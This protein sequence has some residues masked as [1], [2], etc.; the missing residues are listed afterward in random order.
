MRRLITLLFI[1]ALVAGLGLTIF[2]PAHDLTPP[3]QIA[4]ALLLALVILDRLF[5]LFP[6]RRRSRIPPSQVAEI[7]RLYFRAMREM[8]NEHANL[9][10]VINDLQRIL[11]IDPRYKNARHYLKRALILQAEGGSLSSNS[12]NNRSRTSAEFMRLQEQLI[13]PDPAVR[14]SVVMELIQYG[15]VA[16]DPLIAL[17]MDEDSDVRVHAATALGWVGGRDAVQPLMVALEDDNPYVRR[18]AARAM[19]WVVD[20][21]AIEGLI[22]ALKDEDNYVRQYA[23]RALGWSQDRRAVGPLLELLSAEQN[24]DVRDYAFTALDDLGERN[25]RVERPVEVAE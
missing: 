11:S 8:L 5:G 18:Y 3:L 7:E 23:A 12:A 6:P 22:R 20:E 21:T 15:E 4:A 19:C 14:K 10:Q 25:V 16:T 24:A 1:F 13:D 9:V 2:A 17:L